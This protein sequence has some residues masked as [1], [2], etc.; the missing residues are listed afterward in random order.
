MWAKKNL[1]NVLRADSADYP[2][3]V[4]NGLKKDRA[5]NK[6]FALYAFR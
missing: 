5:Q 4:S 1:K 3:L 2:A 6:N